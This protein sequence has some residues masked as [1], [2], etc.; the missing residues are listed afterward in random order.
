MVI[1]S[2]LASMS[3]EALI[4]YIKIIIQEQ[5]DDDLNTNTAQTRW[6]YTCNIYSRTTDRLIST[7]YYLTE[8]DCH[9]LH[10][11]CRDRVE[12]TYNSVSTMDRD[13]AV[14]FHN[15]NYRRVCISQGVIV[16][17]PQ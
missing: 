8:E 10:T 16:M 6:V 1:N 17:E 4:D 5:L 11:T 3:D 2:M 14:A 12:I 7:A 9:R 13:Y 15:S